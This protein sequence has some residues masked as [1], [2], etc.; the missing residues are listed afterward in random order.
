M[1]MMMM[2]IC[3]SY[4]HACLSGSLIAAIDGDGDDHGG[5]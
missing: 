1:M 3:T 5:N 2:M 4:Q